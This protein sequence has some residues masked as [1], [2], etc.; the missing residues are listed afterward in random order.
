NYNVNFGYPGDGFGFD[1]DN[2]VYMDN[3][4]LE[5]TSKPP[6]PPLPTVSYTIVD[7]NFDD[8]P[9]W[10]DYNY[11]WSANSVHP[12][13]SSSH[14]APEYGVDDSAAWIFQ[15]DT[16]ALASDPPE[17]AGGGTGGGGPADY[18]RF[19]TPDMTAY[20]L[21]FDARVEGLNPQNFATTCS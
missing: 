19:T 9:A 3:I 8:K 11:E 12:V 21:T 16:A 4:T 17:W 1:A 7:W 13:P 14:A 18:S 10:Y 15:L 2:V 6:P 20:K 5:T